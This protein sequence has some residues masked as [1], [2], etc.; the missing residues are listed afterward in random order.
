MNE[1]NEKP[2]LLICCSG[3][4]NN[5]I[6]S[7][8]VFLDV[9]S[10]VKEGSDSFAGPLSEYDLI[11]YDLLD[12][13]NLVSENRKQQFLKFLKT[14]KPVIFTLR[15]F[16][17]NKNINNYQILD[18]IFSPILKYNRYEIGTRTFTT[19]NGS[20]S[21][22]S[23]YLNG[24]SSGYEISIDNSEVNS[25]IISLAD[26]TE[27]NSIAFYLKEYPN[28]Y[29]LPWNQNKLGLLWEN[30]VQLAKDS[31]IQG[32]KI[33]EWVNDYSFPELSN[34]KLEIEKLD[35]KIVE[36]DI[37]K[38]LKEN[39]KVN[40]ERIKNTLLY[41][42]GRILEEV[43]KEV[44][45]S[46]GIIVNSNSGNADLSFLFAKNHYVSEIKGCEGSCLKKFVGQLKNHISEYE[47]ANEVNVKGILIINAWR[48]LPLEKR[49]KEDTKIFPIESVN[50]ARIS[51]IVLITTQQLFVA[52]CDKLKGEFD[53][54]EFIKKID[55]TKGILE[56][57]NDIEKYKVKSENEDEKSID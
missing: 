15:Q 52:Y 35:K 14:G 37:E 27:G 12:T 56:G 33:E 20:Q 57:Y 45:K 16:S 42:D 11:L 28:C 21:I 38:T 9:R 25:S 55:D 19:K 30:I 46:L 18:D 13:T 8:E 1:M 23:E 43:V 51:N 3:T 17:Q 36:L 39:D 48:K 40:L 2:S 7:N 41:R 26:N 10:F 44:L 22:F 29:L 4:F 34:I 49:D 54:K 24:N 53:L 6:K 32:E 50:V 31:R 47:T 5:F